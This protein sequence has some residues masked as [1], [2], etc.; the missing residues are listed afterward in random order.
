MGIRVLDALKP[1]LNKTGSLLYKPFNFT[2]YLKLGFVAWICALNIGG[3][4]NRFGNIGRSAPDNWL[5]GFWEKCNDLFYGE[6]GFVENLAAIAGVEVST[7]WLI[8]GISA[9]VIVLLIGIAVLLFWLKSRFNF[10]WLYDLVG[11]RYDIGEPWKEF[12]TEGNS[13][14]GGLLLLNV[15]IYA[16]YTVFLVAALA[17]GVG[18]LK[19]GALLGG[20]PGWTPG[21]VAAVVLICIGVVLAWVLMIY[22]LYVTCFCAPLMFYRRSRFVEAWHE[23]NA[24]LGRNFWG[25]VR[26]GLLIAGLWCGVAFALVALY[27]CTCCIAC[28]LMMLPFCGAVIL[29]PCYVFFRYYTLEILSQAMQPEEQC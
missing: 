19:Q 21:A 2:N 23:V 11:H 26:C 9:I 10:I 15:A 17:L 24:L 28:C 6:G 7:V 1:A 5:V 14:F 13:L 22:T 18:W 20:S 16:V 8:A 29:L 3:V 4:G 12:K 27:V 25:F